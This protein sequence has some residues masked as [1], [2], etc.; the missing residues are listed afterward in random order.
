MH[1]DLESLKDR[2]LEQKAVKSARSGRQKVNNYIRYI[3]NQEWKRESSTHKAANWSQQFLR[4]KYKKGRPQCTK[5]WSQQVLRRA[6]SSRRS[7]LTLDRCPSG[8]SVVQDQSCQNHQ[9]VDL[10]RKITKS[11]RLVFVIYLGAKDQ[12]FQQLLSERGLKWERWT[13]QASQNVPKTRR[14]WKGTSWT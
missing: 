7:V 13:L 12:T 4:R 1:Y 14:F 9:Q 6:P 10:R 3:K 2:E 11:S 8:R 5:R